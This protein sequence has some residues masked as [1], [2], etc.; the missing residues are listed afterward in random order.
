[1][2]RQLFARWAQQKGLRLEAGL[3]SLLSTNQL[4]VAFGHDSYA[5]RRAL[6]KQKHQEAQGGLE[7]TKPTVEGNLEPTVA[8]AD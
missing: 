3:N 4:L 5:A 6:L 8:T 1:M 2:G 7:P